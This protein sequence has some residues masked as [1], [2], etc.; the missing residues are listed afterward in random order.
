[1]PDAKILRVGVIDVVSFARRDVT[2][3]KE[4]SCS[5]EGVVDDGFTVDF[6]EDGGG[7]G[8]VNEFR[9]CCCDALSSDELMDADVRDKGDRPFCGRSLGPFSKGL[10]CKIDGGCRSDFNDS[11]SFCSLW[12]GRLVFVPVV[13][14]I[15]SQDHCPYIPLDFFF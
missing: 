3:D 1:M 15:K 9:S 2:A 14:I 11:R 5:C 4:N 13:L 6:A 10:I 8:N 12:V 7:T